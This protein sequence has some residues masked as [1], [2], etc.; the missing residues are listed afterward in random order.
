MVDS[1]N[2]GVSRFR[3]GYFSKNREKFIDLVE[4]GQNPHTLFINCAD[5]RLV[6]LAFPHPDP[7]KIFILRNVGIMVPPCIADD[8]C[9]S[10]GSAFEY[11]TAVLGVC[12]IVVRLSGR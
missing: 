9:N 8:S 1:L 2:K 4:N 12:E 7:G 3:K 10:T 5:S 6:P 11:A